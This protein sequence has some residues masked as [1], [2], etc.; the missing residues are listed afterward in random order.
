MSRTATIEE[1]KAILSEAEKAGAPQGELEEQRAKIASLASEAYQIDSDDDTP[2]PG[3][4]RGFLNSRDP[5]AKEV[6]VSLEDESPLEAAVRNEL[7]PGYVLSEIY[8]EEE[9]LLELTCCD[10]KKMPLQLLQQLPNLRTLL[11]RQNPVAI[12]G[13]KELIHL[14]SHTSLTHLDLYE[15][16]LEDIAALSALTNLRHLDLSYNS[17]RSFEHV[18]PLVELDEL[19]LVRNKISTMEATLQSL[20]NLTLLELGNNRLKTIENLEICT[21]LRSLWLGKNKLTAITGLETLAQLKQLS[22][23]TNRITKIEGLTKLC[24]LEELYL[25][26]NGIEKI[27]GLDALVN[28]KILD[29]AGNFIQHVENVEKLGQLEDFWFNDNK[30]FENLDEIDK[31][32]NSTL[33]TIY[34]YGTPACKNAGTAYRSRVKALL[35]SIQQIDDR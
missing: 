27:E 13:G 28:L 29:L 10:L 15:T 33:S 30:K 35:P 34:L 17:L 14:S 6:E 24:S 18:M 16:E 25:S 2:E 32:A 9:Q 23:Q 7:P 31:F 12:A 5:D 22:L 19:Y 11:L 21:N 4:Q 26:Q 20:P 8:D 3:I 1:L